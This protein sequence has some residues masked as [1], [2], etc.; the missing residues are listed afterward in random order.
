MGAVQC[1]EQGT[2]YLPLGNLEIPP[3]P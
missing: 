1:G 3:H 2:S